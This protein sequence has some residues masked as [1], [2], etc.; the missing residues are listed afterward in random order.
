[1]RKTKKVKIKSRGAKE[2]LLCIVLISV[3][4]QSQKNLRLTT[5]RPPHRCGV[6]VYRLRRRINREAGDASESAVFDFM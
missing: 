5:L 4:R 1:M 2:R 6:A 3:V